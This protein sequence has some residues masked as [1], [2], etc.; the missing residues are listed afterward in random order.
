MFPFPLTE[1]L[2]LEEEGEGRAV[3]DFGNFFR[4]TRVGCMAV[5]MVARKGLGQA[6]GSYPHDG[7]A[8]VNS[9]NRGGSVVIFSSCFI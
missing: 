1:A 8:G 7:E 3:Y 9:V 6:G 2:V 5:L 4:D